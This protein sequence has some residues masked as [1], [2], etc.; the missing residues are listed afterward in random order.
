MN[1]AYSSYLPFA[2]PI[3]DRAA[4]LRGLADAPRHKQYGSA[5][6]DIGRAYAMES[7]DNY[8]RAADQANFNYD[9]Q[10]TG[11]QQ[12]LAL[13]GLRN[14]SED[15]RRQRELAAARLGNMRGALNALL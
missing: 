15:L 2:P 7:Q 4:A 9:V 13:S 12:S 6:G 8:N 11:A 10:R 14:M 1:A 5:Y 3:Q